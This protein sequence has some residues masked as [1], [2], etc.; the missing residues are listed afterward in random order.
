MKFG[1][2]MQGME[3]RFIGL[4]TS[5]SVEP[6]CGS[7]PAVGRFVTVTVLLTCHPFPDRNVGL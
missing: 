5:L 2:E 6:Q 7:C 3:V 4:S 1:E